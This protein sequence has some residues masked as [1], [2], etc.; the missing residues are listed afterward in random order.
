MGLPRRSALI[1]KR[2]RY[3]ARLEISREQRA[4]A[5]RQDQCR[6][7]I[8]FEPVAADKIEMFFTDANRANGKQAEIDAFR[9]VYL[10]QKGPLRIPVFL[11][12]HPVV[13]IAE[14]R[15][16]LG[17]GNQRAVVGGNIKKIEL[18]RLG[19]AGRIVVILPS[20]GLRPAEFYGQSEGGFSVANSLH[21]LPPSFPSLAVSPA[22]P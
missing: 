5:P 15:R 11:R 9:Q 14:A 4:H 13:F 1:G 8:P 22:D 2:G 20:I 10:A 19:D 3:E 12:G 7:K 17:G 21:P 16:P 6:E 18:L